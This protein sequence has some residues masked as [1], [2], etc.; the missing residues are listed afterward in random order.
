MGFWSLPAG[1]WGGAPYDWSQP[2]LGLACGALHTPKL[3]GLP[4]SGAG[5]ALFLARDARTDIRPVA[6]LLPA[7][8]KR[9]DPRPHCADP[10]SLF[11]GLDERRR[12]VRLAQELWRRR[13]PRACRIS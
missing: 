5:I 12:L 13:I 8:R 4:L 9:Y 2:W 3:S 6:G 7:A 10:G 11:A 1:L